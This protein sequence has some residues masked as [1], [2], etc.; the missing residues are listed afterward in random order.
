MRKTLVLLVCIGMYP[1]VSRI[2]PCVSHV[3]PYVTRMLVICIRICICML[4]MLLVCYSYVTRM[5]SR[6]VLVI[7]TKYR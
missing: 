1:Y 7:I 3:Y 4:S 6:G 2:Y 5:C